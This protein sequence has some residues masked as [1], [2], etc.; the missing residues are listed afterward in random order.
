MAEKKNVKY[1]AGGEVKVVNG[2]V[3][4]RTMGGYELDFYHDD[5]DLVKPENECSREDALKEFV[6]LYGTSKGFDS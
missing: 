5:D 1:Y 3:Y 6:K 4:S 2:V